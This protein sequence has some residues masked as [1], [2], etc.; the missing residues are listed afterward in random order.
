MNLSSKKFQDHLDR[1]E[2]SMTARGY[3]DHLKG[4]KNAGEVIQATKLIP[5]IGSKR[6]I[7]EAEQTRKLKGSSLEQLVKGTINCI[8][9]AVSLVNISRS[10]SQLPGKADDKPRTCLNDP[11]VDKQLQRSL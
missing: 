1:K 7:E 2:V 8:L 11:T 10:E 4:S 9:A 3:L 5:F 6:E